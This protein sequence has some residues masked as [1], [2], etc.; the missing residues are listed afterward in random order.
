[1]KT[2]TPSQT[3]T[4]P[5]VSTSASFNDLPNDAFLHIFSSLTVAETVNIRSVDTYLRDLVDT[6]KTTGDLREPLSGDNAKFD[7]VQVV[8]HLTGRYHISDNTLY[9]ALVQ[10]VDQG[11][12]RFARLDR[13]ARQIIQASDT[14]GVFVDRDDI[15]RRAVDNGDLRGVQ[16]MLDEGGANPAHHADAAIRAAMYNN[17]PQM[18]AILLNDARTLTSPDRGTL[19]NQYPPLIASAHAGNAEI[20][21]MLLANDR[22][23]VDEEGWDALVR[24]VKSGHANIVDVLIADDRIDPTTDLE[25]LLI[26]NIYLTNDDTLRTLIDTPAIR[27]HN[28]GTEALVCE[29]ALGSE[30][31]VAELLASGANPSAYNSAA[32]RESVNRGQLTTVQQLLTDGRSDVNVVL[33]DELTHVAYENNVDVLSALLEQPNIQLG[34]EG[35]M[36]L[37]IALNRGFLDIAHILI[38][39]GNFDISQRDN[40]ALRRASALH[41]LPLIQKLMKDPRVQEKNQGDEYFIGAAAS[42]QTDLVKEL[43]NRPDLSPTAYSGMAL[44]LAA[45]NGYPDTV[46]VLLSDSR[47]NASIN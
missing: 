14:R 10:S 43:L 41:D 36:A 7:L 22:V 28:Q 45:A 17:Q 33:R 1:M 35:V 34:R 26:G 25:E 11:F 12:D 4:E 9:A 46:D 42:G 44:R 37:D 6:H 20:V 15:L 23:N 19:R 2:N 32:L 3:P 16:F 39:N 38:D 31:G 30:Q 5:L 21:T 8:Q 13:F 40:S 18:V 27:A 24:A 47:I 29:A